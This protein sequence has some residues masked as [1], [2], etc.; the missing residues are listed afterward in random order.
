MEES[1]TYLMILEQ[2]EERA[3]REDV[4]EAGEIRLGG[5]DQATR[6]ELASVTDLGRFKRMHRAAL[7]ATNWREILDTP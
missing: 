2:G 3:R 6:A 7:T 5:C 1:D 4:L